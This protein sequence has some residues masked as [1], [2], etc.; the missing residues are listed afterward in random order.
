MKL[1]TG[2]IE[3]RFAVAIPVRITSLDRLW[4]TEEAIT[5]NTSLTGAR[6]LVRNTWRRGEEVLVESPKV[7]RPYQATVIYCQR[8]KS[9]GT[10][11]GVRLTG[12]RPDWMSGDGQMK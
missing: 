10:A 11:I 4:L 12:G 2:R 9:G 3:K 7:S 8:L 6:I 5:E 1:E